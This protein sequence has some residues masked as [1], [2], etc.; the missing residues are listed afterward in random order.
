[1]LKR[2]RVVPPWIVGIA[3]IIGTIVLVTRGEY[4]A[5]AKY[6]RACQAKLPAASAARTTDKSSGEQECQEPKEY[7]PWEYMLLSWPEGITTWALLATLGAIIW[8]AVETRRAA[9][10]TAESANAAYGSVVWAQ[11]QWELMKEKERARLEVKSGSPLTIDR[12]L[13]LWAINT[14]IKLRNIGSSRAF[15]T[16]A[17]GAM[18]LKDGNGTYS[19]ELGDF[20]TLSLPDQFVDPSDTTIEIPL[21]LLPAGFEQD[22]TIGQFADDLHEGNKSIALHGFI[23]YD[24]LSM[25]FRKDFGYTWRVF[26]GLGYLAG[27]IGSVGG[28]QTAEERIGEGYWTIDPGKERPEYPV[29]RSPYSQHGDSDSD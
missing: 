17:G 25:R 3:I 19:R 6:K 24:T 26:D 5:A 29:S 14:N 18:I 9:K 4:E 15:I 27:L 22:F 23:E 13:N 8:Q 10:A 1:M 20:D 16:G 11:A 28:T 7:M 12:V 2:L 21:T